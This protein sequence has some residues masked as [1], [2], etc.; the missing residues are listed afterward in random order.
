MIWQFDAKIRRLLSKN[1]IFCEVEEIA[2]ICSTVPINPP[3]TF[4]EAV[5]A[6]WTIKTAVELAVPFNVHA[7][8]RLD[9]ILYPYYNKDITDGILERE[10]AREIL[11]E[12]FLKIMSHNMRPYSNASTEF[13]QRYEGSEPVT[14][15]GITKTGED[16]TNELTYVILEAAD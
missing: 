1:Y 10:E 13:S 16:A 3:K 6:Y 11:E 8:G 9:Q 15:G 7:P 4:K 5:Q 2:K 14:L 12:L